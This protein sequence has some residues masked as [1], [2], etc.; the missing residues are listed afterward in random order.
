MR[1]KSENGFSNLCVLG[2]SIAALA[3]ALGSSARAQ[4][5][6]PTGS[7][8]VAQTTF[9]IPPSPYTWTRETGNVYL[10]RLTSGSH[11][12]NTALNYRSWEI[13]TTGASAAGDMTEML[14]FDVRID[15]NLQPSNGSR[16]VLT[17]ETETLSGSPTHPFVPI[18]AVNGVQCGQSTACLFPYIPPAENQVTGTPVSDVAY[19]ADWGNGGKTIRVG[20]FLA[21]VCTYIGTGA[22]RPYGCQES[23]TTSPIVPTDGAP[24]IFTL[25]FR[26]RN[27]PVAFP[28]PLTKSVSQVIKEGA[29]SKELKAVINVQSNGPTVSCALTDI[30]FPGD[31]QI[32]VNTSKLSAAAASAGAPIKSLVVTA[33]ELPG[34]PSSTIPPAESDDVKGYANFTGTQAI[35]GFQNTTDGSDNQY[36]VQFNVMDEAGVMPTPANATGCV[37]GNAGQGVQTS[38][39]QSFLGSSACFIATATFRSERH[40]V[41]EGLR[42]FR[43]QF[44]AQSRLG[45]SLIRTYYDWSPRAAALVDTYPVLRMPSLFILAPVEFVALLLLH[46]LLGLGWATAWSGLGW[47]LFR[48]R[49]RASA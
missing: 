26:V 23:A 40:P 19:A 12:V 15:D 38:A 30:Y 11:G 34:S 25:N 8:V 21:D 43:D 36:V 41:V 5:T 29:I 45:R 33:E 4:T 16:L 46:P 13:L 27:V 39:I 17:V 35:T 20:F 44:L 24:A 14:Y 1:F 10:A 47:M 32:L 2:V 37:L 42:D 3:C 6:A 7:T 18:Y 31:Q 49:R 9:L 22:V 28:D 48:Q